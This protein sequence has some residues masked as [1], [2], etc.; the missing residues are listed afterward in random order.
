MDLGLRASSVRGR[1]LAALGH[2]DFRML[3]TANLL[4]GS[5]AWALIVARGWLVLDMSESSLLVGIATFLA[6]IPRIVVTPFAGLLADRM[7]RRTLL[8]LAHGLNLVH[9]LA[10]GTLALTGVIE[11]WHLM[12]LSL[13]NGVSRS[14]QMPTGGALLPNLVP[15]EQLLNATALNAS[16]MHGSRLLGPLVIAPLLTSTNVGWAFLACATMYALTLLQI[17]RI[18]TVST[19]EV[20]AGEGFA[21][22]LLAGLSYTYRDPLL[23]SLVLLV[24]AHC[25]LTMAFESLL[26]LFAQTKLQTEGA[27]VGYLMMAVGA[28]ALL[29][30]IG[31]AGV[32]SSLIRGR[33][34]FGMGL[35]SGVAS[36]ALAIAPNTLLALLAAA[37]LGAGGAGYMTLNATMVQAIVPDAIRGRISG[38]QL[39]HTG[40]VM[41]FMNLG[42]GAMADVFRDPL[43]FG[44]SGASLLLVGAGGLFVAV[45]FFSI[46]RAPLRRIYTEGTPTLSVAAHAVAPS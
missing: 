3:W 42:N 31:L 9:V 14:I 8:A 41:A 37:S 17:L 46:L 13:V 28:G 34:F 45:M 36:V 21:A 11:V 19:G 10:L 27:G 4:A 32:Q 20:R 23:L 40:G 6:M 35:F 5:A 24:A 38:V 43:V 18:R 16:T 26:P 39:W 25:A 29:T 1:F 44:F 7:N 33:L 30:S 15:R 22:K 2:R 12:V